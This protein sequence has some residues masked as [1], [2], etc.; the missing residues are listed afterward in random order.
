MQER[1]VRFETETNLADRFHPA[2]ADIRVLG[3]DMSVAEVA[4][5]RLVVPNTGRTGERVNQVDGLGRRDWYVAGRELQAGLA[6]QI[7]SPP[8]Q[9]ALPCCV[10]GLVQIGACGF[11]LRDRRGEAKLHDR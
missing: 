1:P 4:L 11:D 3:N 8:V 2:L 6:G 10:E 5:E 9:R 7:E